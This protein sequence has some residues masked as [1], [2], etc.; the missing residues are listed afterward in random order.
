MRIEMKLVEFRPQHLEPQGASNP[1]GLPQF[2]ERLRVPN[3]TCKV[4]RDAKTPIFETRLL[5]ESCPPMI[6]IISHRP[7]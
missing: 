3:R 6:F 2:L 1:D 4:A 7:G 5:D